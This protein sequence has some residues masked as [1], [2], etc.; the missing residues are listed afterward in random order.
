MKVIVKC[1]DLSTY[2]Q[3]NE[4]A[5]IIESR[6]KGLNIPYV[7]T[8]D[9]TDENDGEFDPLEKI[10]KTGSAKEYLAKVDWWYDNLPASY[11]EKLQKDFPDVNV[12]Q[13]LE[14]LRK[15]QHEWPSKRKTLMNTFIRK[16]LGKDQ[17]RIEYSKR[18]RDRFN[19]GNGQSLVNDRYGV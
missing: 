18:N 6:L 1:P 7:V 2:E 9:D 4:I 12:K 8:V 17:K 10:D 16:C 11:I 15:W 14:C 13:K 5:H 3:Y 19:G